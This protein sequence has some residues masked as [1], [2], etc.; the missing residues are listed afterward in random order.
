MVAFGKALKQSLGKQGGDIE[1][2]SIPEICSKKV[3]LTEMV[4]RES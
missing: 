1:E 3:K 2:T 4:Q